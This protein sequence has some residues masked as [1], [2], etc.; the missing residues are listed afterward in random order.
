MVI[1]EGRGEE[2]EDEGKKLKEVGGEKWGVGYI[3]LYTCVVI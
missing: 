3:S 1:T 2:E